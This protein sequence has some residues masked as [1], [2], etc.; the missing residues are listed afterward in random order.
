M[1]SRIQKDPPR[2]CHPSQRKKHVKL[3][4]LLEICLSI[5]SKHR[6]TKIVF[7]PC[8][9][10]KCIGF[11]SKSLVPTMIP[12]MHAVL[13]YMFFISLLDMGGSE[14]GLI[15][16]YFIL[17]STLVLSFLS[18]KTCI[19]HQLLRSWVKVSFCGYTSTC[20]MG[21][22]LTPITSSAPHIGEYMLI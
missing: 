13:L 18:K 1:S 4:A 11:K 21:L 5:I 9:L 15:P 2:S 7:K 14:F 17:L 6:P 20:C 16:I 8:D 19:I 12:L 10:K 22:Y 3:V